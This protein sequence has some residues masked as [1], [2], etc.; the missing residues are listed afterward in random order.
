MLGRWKTNDA[1]PRPLGS[2]GRPPSSS[3][4]LSEVPQCPWL[5]Q[6]TP[7]LWRPSREL[8][9]T[10]GRSDVIYSWHLCC[11]WLRGALQQNNK[12]Q[13]HLSCWRL[14]IKW[15]AWADRAFNEHD[16]GCSFRNQ[17]TLKL[18]L[19]EGVSSKG[20]G[21]MCWEWRHPTSGKVAEMGRPG[22]ESWLCLCVWL[23]VSYVT[24]SR[25]CF[26]FCEMEVYRSAS[27][28][29]CC[30]NK[31]PLESCGLKQPKFM[32]H[33]CS[34]ASSFWDPDWWNMPRA[35]WTIT[36]HGGNC[37]LVLK[38][39]SQEQLMSLPLP[40]RWSRQ[41]TWPCLTSGAVV[42]GEKKNPT[43]W[44]LAG[45]PEGLVFIRDSCSAEPS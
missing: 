24:S 12:L 40:S 38:A 42:R 37:A 26:F 16:R 2:W 28:Q 18:A 45:K 17:K 21:W 14:L 6:A 23:W 31:Q 30:S 27:A 5:L 11:H 29:L 41:V 43:M 10:L 34:M 3:V 9:L 44:P 33:L 7:C 20:F 22:F 32:S 4:V 25:L 15:A 19:I 13:G 39:S 1:H 36:G 35:T 8:G